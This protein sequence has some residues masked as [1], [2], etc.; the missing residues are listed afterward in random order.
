MTRLS[1][2]LAAA[3][4]AAL[5]A[6]PAGAQNATWLESF[7]APNDAGFL[8]SFTW[9][10]L[11]TTDPYTFGLYEFNGLTLTSGAL[12]SQ[13]LTNS[14][15]VSDIQTFFPHAAVTAGQQYAI[16]VTQQSGEQAFLDQNPYP[17]GRAWTFSPSLHVY[18]SGAGMEDVPSF[19][20]TFAPAV[21]VTP[22]P[23]SLALL[24]TGLV[25]F[26]LVRRRRRG[27]A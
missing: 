11:G 20:V 24:A 22:E 1:R 4:V 2:L 8:E 26:A 5:A 23:A 10:G 9:Q 13:T 6:Q 21:V 27:A 17:G 3:A 25:G 18:D 16:G 7:T 19:S 12:W 14:V 15:S